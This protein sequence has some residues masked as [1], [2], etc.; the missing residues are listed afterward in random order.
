MA[1]SLIREILEMI[2]VVAAA[3]IFYFGL[4][5]A[6]GTPTPMFSVVSESMEPTLHVG[7]MVVIAS[8]EY[9]T[10]DIVVYMRGNMPIIHR[11]IE[12]REKG[13]IIKGDNNPVPDPGIVKKEQIMGKTIIAAPVIGVPRL[14]MF[15]LGV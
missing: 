3:Y 9:H 14:L 6:L 1:K 11:I 12:E 10:G 15:W 8:G 13:Y 4:G 2:A 7:D 5:L